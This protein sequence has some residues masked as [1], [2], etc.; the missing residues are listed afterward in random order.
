MEIPRLQCK[1]SQYCVRSTIFHNKRCSQAVCGRPVLYFMSMMTMFSQGYSEI[2][3]CSLQW[4]QWATL[5]VQSSRDQLSSLSPH[6]LILQTD[7]ITLFA[8]III[9]S[10]VG[11][12]YFCLDSI[13]EQCITFT[14]RMTVRHVQE[15][16]K[17]GIWIQGK[18]RKKEERIQ[19]LGKWDGGMEQRKVVAIRKWDRAR[20]RL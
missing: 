10:Y 5:W 18:K 2:E 9:Y 1:S 16:G 11:R 19:K 17:C 14:N 7:L 15:V 13:A 8:F 20:G 6:P 4:A 12:I 3:L